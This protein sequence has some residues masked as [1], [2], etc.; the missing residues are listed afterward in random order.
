ML[1]K[2]RKNTSNLELNALFLIIGSLFIVKLVFLG[3][4]LMEVN[5]SI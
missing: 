4:V 5:S 1:D 2:I 3:N